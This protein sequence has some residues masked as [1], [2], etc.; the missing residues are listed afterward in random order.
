[1]LCL[2]G[3]LRGPASVHAG[4]QHVEVLT[5]AEAKSDQ[6]FKKAIDDAIAVVEAEWK[7]QQEQELAQK[8]RLDKA[9]QQAMVVREIMIVPLLNDLRDGFAAD[10]KKVL[11]EW[12]VY[13]DGDIDAVSGTAV[14]ANLGDGGPTC[15][16]IKAEASVAEQGTALNLSVVCSCGDP[17]DAPTSK[18]RQLFEKTK[19]APMMKFDELGS[20]MWFHKQL[21]E[22]A[23]MCVLTKMRRSSKS[24]ADCAAQA[25]VEV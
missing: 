15:F 19:M 1:V 22:C 8:R 10:G 20:Q 13:S 5:M 17:K 18:V 16:T 2:E 7:A 23:R 25:A 21:E 11:P 9:R 14:A 6:G 4:A 24:D 12:Q 3:C